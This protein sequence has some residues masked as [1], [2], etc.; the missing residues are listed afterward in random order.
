M[1]KILFTGFEGEQNTSKLLLDKLNACDKL[2]LENDFRISESQ[3]S[4]VLRDD[5]FDC[6][7]MFGLKPG[8]KHVQIETQAKR[9][10]IVLQTK[11]DYYG[12]GKHFADLGYQVVVSD[13]AGDYLCNNI[14]F[15]CLE[16]GANAV[17]VHIP[18]LGMGFC[19][20]KFAEDIQGFVL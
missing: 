8:I 6:V 12:L 4:N 3:L 19:L 11:F 2:Y 7:I 17:F 18:T 14:Y 1:S 5:E 16:C 20:D 15:H 9:D 13:D 10:G